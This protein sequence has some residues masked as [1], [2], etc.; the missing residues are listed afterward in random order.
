[1]HDILKVN[2]INIGLGSINYGKM[3]TTLVG[4]GNHL[5]VPSATPASLPTIRPTALPTIKPTAVPSTSLPTTAAP[6]PVPSFA[7][8]TVVTIVAVRQVTNNHIIL[9]QKIL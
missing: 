4:L 3:E 9:R 5:E 7:P 8:T 1:M 6:T 2:I